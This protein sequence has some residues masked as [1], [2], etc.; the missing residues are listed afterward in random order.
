M[1][2]LRIRI[3]LEDIF[4]FMFFKIRRLNCQSLSFVLYILLGERLKILNE[5]I[6]D[7]LLCCWVENKSKTIAKKLGFVFPLQ[8]PPKQYYFWP[9]LT[10]WLPE[11][12]TFHRAS[13]C[14]TNLYCLIPQKHLVSLQCFCWTNCM[15]AFSQSVIAFI[16]KLVL[17]II[18][19]C[20]KNNCGYGGC[21]PEFNIY[22]LWPEGHLNLRRVI[23][24]AP[25][26]QHVLSLWKNTISLDFQSSDFPPFVTLD[27]AAKLSYEKL[28]LGSINPRSFYES[29]NCIKVLHNAL[30]IPTKES[31]ISFFS[32]DF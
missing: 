26:G 11:S 21:S 16:R 31:H 1:Y 4:T 12:Y 15:E 8:N 32:G 10:S 5:A 14:W 3:G 22:P 7:Y 28:D 19:K 23:R 6:L 20:N 29:F 25:F 30:C 18:K 13:K 24:W 27:G 17:N 9:R 2:N